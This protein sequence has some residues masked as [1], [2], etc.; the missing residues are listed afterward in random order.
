MACF[1]VP[2]VEAIVVSSVKKIAKNESENIFAKKIHLLTKMLYGGSFL[3]AVEHIWHGEIVPFPP[4]LTAIKDPQDTIAMFHEMA[5]VGVSMAV[6]VT[7]VW[8]LMVVVS[9][10]IEKR[11]SKRTGIS[12]NVGI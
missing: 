6:L 10:A 5:T 2:L 9:N 3:L 1:T 12:F 7:G 8:A 11:N 4:F